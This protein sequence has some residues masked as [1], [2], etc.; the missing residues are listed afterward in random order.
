MT[1][2]TDSF[3]DAQ[4]DLPPPGPIVRPM[5]TRD[6]WDL[7]VMIQRHTPNGLNG[8]QFMD[9]KTRLENSLHKILVDVQPGGKLSGF[10]IAMTQADTFDN[11]R[12]LLKMMTFPE[13]DR[14][15]ATKRLL[16]GIARQVMA[17]GQTSLEVLVAD[18]DAVLT[19]VCNLYAGTFQKAAPG[20]GDFPTQNAKVFSITNLTQHFGYKPPTPK[21]DDLTP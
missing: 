17:A 4:D 7:T 9:M 15:D 5:E 11:P 8:A 19:S 3:D 6:A 1:R 12:G 21:P 13:Y 10:A 18:H 14:V 16:R 2:L 20:T